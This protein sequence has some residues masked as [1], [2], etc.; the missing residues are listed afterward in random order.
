MK[1]QLTSDEEEKN[2]LLHAIRHND[3]HTFKIFCFAEHKLVEVIAIS[4]DR[5]GDINYRIDLNHDNL[6]VIFN[7]LKHNNAILTL[8]IWG[9]NNGIMKKQALGLQTLL[10]CN[11]TI[12]T[13]EF[14]ASDL[15]G[16]NIKLIVDGLMYNSHVK[17]LTINNTI[18]DVED[19]GRIWYL[20]KNPSLPIISLSLKG[21]KSPTVTFE[22]FPS[23][24]TT[25]TTLDLSETGIRD[26]K[27][28]SI[29][30]IL[31]LNRSITTLILED[32]HITNAGIGQ[33]QRSLESNTT[34]KVLDLKNN[35]IRNQGGYYL[36]YALTNNITISTVNLE[37]NLISNNNL[38][39]RISQLCEQ[40]KNNTR[41]R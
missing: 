21:C 27:I 7:L 8:Q 35:K 1:R 36:L 16:Q 41:N 38:L 34:L 23:H 2:A 15:S 32:N 33:L 18:L 17:H 13:C 37:N 5:R 25:L 20:L 29:G 30:T 10:R 19:I 39:T 28:A 11:Q 6:K 24:I 22:G 9:F 40:N 14:T 12:T 4:P 31:R 26:N 3:L